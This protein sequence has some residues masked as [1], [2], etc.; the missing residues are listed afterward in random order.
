MG[1]KL[2]WDAKVLSESGLEREVG[3]EAWSDHKWVPHLSWKG[4][5]KPIAL[6][7]W[8]PYTCIHVY[9]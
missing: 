3:E 7:V 1:S 2:G 9:M 5:T 6:I 8:W 4:G